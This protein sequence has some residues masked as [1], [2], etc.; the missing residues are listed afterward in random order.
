M[1][2]LMS[3][4]K[5]LEKLATKWYIKEYYGEQLKNTTKE[6]RTEYLRKIRESLNKEDVIKQYFKAKPEMKTQYKAKK[7]RVNKIKTMAGL[8]LLTVSIGTGVIYTMSNNNSKVENQTKIVEAEA[9]N[10]NDTNELLE[11]EEYSKFFEETRDISNTNK[12]DTQI[13]NF[14]KEKIAEEY[15]KQNKNEPINAE[16]L[17]Y[18]NL[19]ENVLVNKDV[20]GNDVSYE[21][22]SQREKIVTTDNQELKKMGICEFKINGKTVAVYDYNGQEIIDSNIEQKEEFFKDTLSLVKTANKLQDIYKY[23]NSETDIK[24][25]ENE[26][27]TTAQK[28]IEK[29]DKQNNKEE[30]V[31]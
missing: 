1:S 5:Q 26:Y 15:N 18:Y 29:S 23:R 27:K 9:I 6:F 24:K 31:R 21:R 4:D 11:Q 28:F 10:Y 20:F 3:L 12:R 16:Q 17:Q 19:N 8:G 2:K 13:I 14:T 30:N 7:Q 25:V 22:V